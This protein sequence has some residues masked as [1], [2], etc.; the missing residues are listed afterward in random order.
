[1]HRT[2]L[3]HS[4]PPCRTDVLALLVQID[5]TVAGWEPYTKSTIDR[6]RQL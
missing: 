1:V 5:T 6:L 4:R 2:G 3:Q